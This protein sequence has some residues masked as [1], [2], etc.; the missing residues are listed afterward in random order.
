VTP[1]TTRWSRASWTPF[2]TE[3]IA[4]H[5]WRTRSQLELAIVEWIGWFNST[6]LHSALG[7]RPPREFERTELSARTVPGLAGFA[8]S[9]THTLRRLET[10]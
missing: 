9:H 2:K 8:G 3:L 10:T 1:T 5:V 4:D 6:R 7:D